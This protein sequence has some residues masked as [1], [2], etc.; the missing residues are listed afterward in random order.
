MDKVQKIREKVEKRYECWKE[1]ESNSHS[2]ELEIRMSEC[3]HLLLM[4]NSLQEEPVSE[5][6]EETANKDYEN[7]LNSV[8]VNFMEAQGITP[9]L[10]AEQIIRAVKHGAQWQ[11]EQMMTKA[12]EAVVSQVP[13]SNEIILYNPSSVYK[14]SLPQEMNKLGLNKGD[15]VKLVII[16]ED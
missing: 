1:K 15:K 10:Y 8:A 13:C 5:E 3:Q 12:V 2:I 7:A 11:K 6:L 4:L 9:N 16:K 14:Y